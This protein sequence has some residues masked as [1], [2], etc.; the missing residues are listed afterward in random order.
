MNAARR[1]CIITGSRAEYGILSS[2]MHEIGRDG[3]L[4]L[5]TLVTGA[6][7]SHKFGMTARE[8][9][10]DGYAVDAEVD[11]KLTDDTPLA[12]AEAT[13]RA[14]T[15]IAKELARLQPDMVVLLGDRYEIL[16][17]A[18]AAFLLGLPIAH[19][20]GGEI[21]EGA[22]DDS[23]RHA[24]T[25]LSHLHF[26]AAAPYARRIMQMG[27]APERVFNVGALGV[28]AAMALRPIDPEALDGDIGIPLRDPVFLVTY[29][30][31]TLRT[32]DEGIVVDSLQSALDKFQEARIVITGVNADPGRSAIAQR[33]IAYAARNPQRV[34]LHES[35]G[36]RRYLSVMRRAAAVIGNS[37]S[38][39]IEAPAFGVPTVNIGARQTGRLKALSVVDCGE[40]AD[41]IATAIARAV[42]PGF[43]A[44][45]AR[46]SL[47]Y[48]GGGT[49]EKIT[50]VIKTADLDRLKHKV[51]NDLPGVEV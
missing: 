47:P 46:Q 15:G 17:A 22:M 51:F 50:A 34:S 21:T 40:S 37:S 1:I 24:I 20:H 49:A 12:V 6:H 2:L 42:D 16:A 41:E 4:V 31:V 28:D 23:I 35:L 44:N 43:Q 7:L 27:E 5:Q 36:Q 38:G 14:A 13:G 33:M 9:E 19:L 48:G 25:K 10:D 3:G 30:P 45:F 26:A 8:I 18:Q 32:G 39:I 11:L 29:H